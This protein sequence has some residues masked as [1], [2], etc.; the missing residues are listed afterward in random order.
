MSYSLYFDLKSTSDH[1]IHR[2]SRNK[3]GCVTRERYYIPHTNTHTNTHTLY[4]FIFWYW[5]T[6][7]EWNNTQCW[8]KIKL[9]VR[10]VCV[11]DAAHIRNAIFSFCLWAIFSFGGEPNRL[12]ESSRA[13]CGSSG[14]VWMCVYA[15]AVRSAMNNRTQTLLCRHKSNSNNN[16]KW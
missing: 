9:T 1:G 3:K 10:A 13:E 16:C 11:R 6:P 8:A 2:T 12:F 14:S 15:V 5:Q 4:P 7:H